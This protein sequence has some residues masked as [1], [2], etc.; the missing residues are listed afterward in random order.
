M[1]QDLISTSK[2]VG[3]S[4]KACS[5]GDVSRELRK[6]AFDRDSRNWDFPKFLSKSRL[7][8]LFSLPLF[9]SSLFTSSSSFPLTTLPSPP[10]QANTMAYVYKVSL[11]FL[12]P[13]LF[14]SRPA[15]NFPPLFLSCSAVR[16]HSAC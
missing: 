12:S 14:K 7:E 10:F 9:F 2:F 6:D 8:I 3:G 4:D 15:Y 16:L 11:S 1:K 5:L 13:S